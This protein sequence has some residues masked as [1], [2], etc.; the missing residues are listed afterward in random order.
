MLHETMR[1]SNAHPPRP[2][3][4]ANETSTRPTSTVVAMSNRDHDAL[5]DFNSEEVA[6]AE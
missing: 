2:R 6:D 3:F 1:A 5:S 4:T